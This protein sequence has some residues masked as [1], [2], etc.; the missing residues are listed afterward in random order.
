MNCEYI[1]NIVKDESFLNKKPIFYI[2]VPWVFV[3]VVSR[4]DLLVF[5]WQGVAVNW[6]EDKNALKWNK[7]KFINNNKKC[8]KKA[9]KKDNQFCPDT[10][11]RQSGEE[12]LLSHGYWKPRNASFLT[13]WVQFE[14]SMAI[15]VQKCSSYGCISRYFNLRQILTNE[16]VRSRTSPKLG[17]LWDPKSP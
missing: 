11:S 1:C 7:T 17:L 15:G 12:P 14:F 3:V 2:W 10:L 6:R 16:Y 9:D 4:F 5:F 8:K 13:S